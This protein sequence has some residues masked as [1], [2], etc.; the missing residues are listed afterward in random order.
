MSTLSKRIL[1]LEAT[2]APGRN[3]AKAEKFGKELFEFVQE[4]FPRIAHRSRMDDLAAC[5]GLPGGHSMLS[6]FADKFSEE[7]FITAARSAYGE[8]W[9]AQMRATLETTLTTITDARGEDGLMEFAKVFPPVLLA[10]RVALGMAEE[11]A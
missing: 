5:C 4:A 11:S 9:Q 2:A 3:R 7:S 10:S 1:A 6:I 8:D